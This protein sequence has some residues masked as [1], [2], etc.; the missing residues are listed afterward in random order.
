MIINNNICTFLFDYKIDVIG[1]DVLKIGEFDGYVLL[2]KE[3][4]FNESKFKANDR[5]KSLQDFL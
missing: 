4:I 5:L 2:D 1:E 3:D